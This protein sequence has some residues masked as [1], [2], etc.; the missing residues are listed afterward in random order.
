MAMQRQEQYGMNILEVSRGYLCFQS[1]LASKWVRKGSEEACVAR[2]EG[3]P[4]VH[5]SAPQDLR[6]FGPFSA[7]ATLR[8]FLG[9]PTRRAAL[10]L[11]GRELLRAVGRIESGPQQ[12]LINSHG[13]SCEHLGTAGG[14]HL[15]RGLGGRHAEASA[16]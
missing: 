4:P 14:H 1:F 6:I 12:G 15:H 11:S 7:S 10:S 9:R 2:G 8:P 16:E 3:E 13:A 5:R